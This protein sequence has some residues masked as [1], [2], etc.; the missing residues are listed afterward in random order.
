MA[1][2][3]RAAT[4]SLPKNWRLYIGNIGGGW[5]VYIILMER[6]SWK[7]KKKKTE[8][9]FENRRDGNPICRL[10]IVTKSGVD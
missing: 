10:H 7:K 1:Y 4:F 5:G 6:Q 9:P 8:S 2:A 3:G